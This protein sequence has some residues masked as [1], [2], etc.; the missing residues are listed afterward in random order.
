MPASLTFTTGDLVTA[1][2]DALVNAVNCEGV[3][4]KGIALQ[5]K[6]AW[7]AMFV[8]YQTLARAGQ[9]QP[10]AM[11]VHHTGSLLGPRFIIN[12][13]T[14]RH[15]KHPSRLDDIHS[16]LAALTETVRDLDIRSIALPAL[17]CGNGGLHWGD[18]RP[19]IEATVHGWSGDVRVVVFE[20]VV[21]A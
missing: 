20:P 9:V 4:G 21:P 8:E 13:P 5:F 15:W 1:D 17:G 10:G 3:M 7:P 2:V 12:F 18:V 14:K 16:G 19:L 11:Q 6:Q